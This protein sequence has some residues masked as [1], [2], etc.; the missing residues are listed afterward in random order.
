M[1]AQKPQ[2]VPDGLSEAQEPTVPDWIRPQH[3]RVPT[4][5]TAAV[6]NWHQESQAR[7]IE[8]ASPA[9]QNALPR[10]PQIVS[11]ATRFQPSHS[12]VAA[13]GEARHPTRRARRRP[14]VRWCLT[15]VKHLHSLRAGRPGS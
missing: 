6:R 5:G 14:G 11:T 3:R 1:A 15:E 2:V 4:P 8:K 9:A 12:P 10:V 7:R 13:C